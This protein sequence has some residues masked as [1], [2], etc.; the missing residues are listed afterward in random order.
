MS[1]SQRKSI[2]CGKGKNG[3]VHSAQ[4]NLK[5]KV[6]A[7]DPKKPGW[8]VSP[9]TAQAVKPVMNAAVTERFSASKPNQAGTLKTATLEPTFDTWSPDDIAL[10]SLALGELRSAIDATKAAADKLH[11]ARK[12]PDRLLFSQINVADVISVQYCA[13]ELLK[14][15]ENMQRKMEACR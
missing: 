5:T 4:F 1:K 11:R 9:E 15:Y 8:P 2:Y 14:A 10:A 7:R 3:P 12:C 13:K 6:Q